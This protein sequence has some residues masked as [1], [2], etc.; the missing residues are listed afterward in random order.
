VFL[1]LRARLVLVL[2]NGP[3]A[4]RKAAMAR[5][6]GAEVRTATVFSPALLDGV[7][8]AI[9]ADAP[10]GDLAALSASAGA[11]GIPV[12]IVDRPEL[13]TAIMPAVVDR[14]PITV[15]ISSG[16]TAP[17][18]ARLIRA[19]IE[20]ML[21]PSIGRLASLAARLREETVR[22]LPDLNARRRM[23]ERVF[24]GTV[25]ARFLAGDESGAEAEYRALL[26]APS[27]ES[28]AAPVF[29]LRAS[30]PDLLTLR[31]ARL[32]GMADAI[33][34]NADV[35]AEVLGLARREAALHLAGPDS[36]AE[37]AAFARR[38]KL[39]VRIDS[40]AGNSEKERAALAEMGIES[41]VIPF[42]A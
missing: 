28:P 26:E 19:R 41:V 36:T 18:L 31:A 23:L 2:G 5:Q 32:L 11:R 15:A 6:A 42:V 10:E 8:L 25:A 24:T 37:L 27:S 39:V 40:E 13:C 9:G 34:H 33:I 16:G 4:M 17:V 14:A 30:D 21:S 1:D 22:R 3:V 20:E 38:G 35:S 7:S 12:N 29:F